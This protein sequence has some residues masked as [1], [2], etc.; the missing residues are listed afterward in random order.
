MVL[1][2]KL[3]HRPGE[4]KREHMLDEVHDMDLKLVFSIWRD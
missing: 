4:T 3:Q 1:D 2:G